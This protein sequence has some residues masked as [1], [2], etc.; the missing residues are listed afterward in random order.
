[1]TIAVIGTIV[2]AAGLIL[3]VFI[4]SRKREDER[5]K[6][7][8]KDFEFS[9]GRVVGQVDEETICKEMFQSGIDYKSA[10]ELYIESKECVKQ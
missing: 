1:M 2:V 9:L 6:L 4:D 7:W 5:F 8:M 10:V 3:Y